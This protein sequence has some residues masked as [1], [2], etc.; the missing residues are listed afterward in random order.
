MTEKEIL[1]AFGERVALHK[2][3]HLGRAK[4]QTIQHAGDLVIDGVRV[5]VKCSKLTKVNAKKRG[6]QFCLRRDGHTDISHSDVVVLVGLGEHCETE[7]VWVI[8]VSVIREDRRKINIVRGSK[9]KWGFWHDRW[10][11]VAAMVEV[12]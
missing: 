8:P 1:G 12:A 10:D 7:K 9:S 6:W 3:R 11:V 2:L 4:R 5:E